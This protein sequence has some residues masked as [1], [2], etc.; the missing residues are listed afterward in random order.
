MGIGSGCGLAVCSQDSILKQ[1]ISYQYKYLVYISRD[2]ST[3][4][5]CSSIMSSK[6]PV[7]PPLD[8]SLHLFE[9]LDFNMTYNADQPFYSFSPENGRKEI[10]D[11][12]HLEF[13]RACHRVAHLLRPA[14]QG[15][16]NEVVAI[17]TLADIVT[18]QAITGGLMKAGIAVS[19]LEIQELNR[20]LL[21]FAFKSHSLY[22][23][24][25]LLRP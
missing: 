10:M 7:L 15:L 21:T 2:V 8:G 6:E 20:N 25:F 22:L 23:L 18:T 9:T 1:L 11:I 13:S 5:T 4:N 14:R 19:S 12:T 16:E 3:F 17:L 24:A